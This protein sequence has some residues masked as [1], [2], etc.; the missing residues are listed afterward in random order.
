M[1]TTK[2]DYLKTYTSFSGADILVSFG[3][4]VIG[5]LQSISW[6]IEREKAPVYTLGS[7]NPRSFSRGKRGI[8]GKMTF[9]VFDYDALRA[10]L[11]EDKNV[12]NQIAP[13]AM[14]TAAPN[15]TQSVNTE[16]EKVALEMSLWNA[17]ASDVNNSSAGSAF[18]PTGTNSKTGTIDLP[19]GA[20][21]NVPP[22]FEILKAENI[23]YADMIPPFDVTITFANEYGQAAFMKIYD[24]E[25]LNEASG[26][27]VD[28][29]VMERDLT[30]VA[31]RISPIMKGVYTREA[32][33]NYTLI[34]PKPVVE[35]I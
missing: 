24:C 32:K 11:V 8:A 27:S 10:A 19:E 9:A 2:Q 33:D 31:R 14:F 35:G 30:Y 5:E 15:A 20:S 23:I 3:P 26:V 28:T 34:T 16:Y 13:Y 1:A 18:G 25:I 22:G 29:I 7:P 12:W 6:G 4:K 21:I 17:K